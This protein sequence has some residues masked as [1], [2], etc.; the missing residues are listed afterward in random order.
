[1]NRSL[2]YA[3]LLVVAALAV[4]CVMQWNANRRVNLEAGALEKTRIEQAAQIEQQEK[5]R[6]TEEGAT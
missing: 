2:Q 3:N 4:L 1:M 5:I 6:K